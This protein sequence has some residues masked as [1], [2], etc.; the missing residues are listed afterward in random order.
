MSSVNKALALAL[1][2]L[3]I[4]AIGLGLLYSNISSLK[5]D[6]KVINSRIT[7]IQENVDRIQSASRGYVTQ[8]QLDEVKNTLDDI[9]KELMRLRE[10]LPNAATQED[11]QNI[12]A[13]ISE[14][15]EELS[16]LQNLEA[17]TSDLKDRI[18]SLAK[19]LN[20]LE[21][22]IQE[23]E[24]RIKFPV[25][26]VDATGSEV[27]VPSKP[28]RIVSLAPSTTEIIYFVGALDR[29]VGVDDYSDYP[30]VVKDMLENGTLTSIGGF[31]NP[32][33]ET[34]L[35]LDP[36]LVI[37]VDSTPHRQVKDVL[38]DY[39]IP[40]ILL[41]QAS[42]DDVKRSIIIA[43]MA[44]GN[45][46]EAVKVLSKINSK[47]A[48]V[49]KAASGIEDPVTVALIVWIN[50]IFVAGNETFQNDI[51]EFAGGVNV[52]ANLSGWP[53]ISPEDLVEANP[54]VILLSGINVTTFI[55]YL[56]SQVGDAA[57]DISAVANGR[58]YTIS[59]DYADMLSRPSPRV[60]DIIP[61]IQYIL[62]PELYGAQVSD[63][64][65]VISPE[66][67]PQVP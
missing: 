32:N 67:L 66:T 11:I 5:E 64:P 44:T 20:E 17:A 29:L 4:I 56:V 23:L 6:I 51:I 50:P 18:D 39:G 35:S 34:I 43:G 9:S 15:Q 63:I 46:D 59:G 3:V 57:L 49:K 14:I 37:G 16:R 53:T 33:I 38:E 30:P 19:Q 25:T 42:I 61:I 12:L 60:A 2:T 26:V 21:G 36:D 27:F 28:E 7:E 47:L 13:T 48:A 40:V 54:D 55:D 65:R 58:V 45:I 1:S 8:Q 41:P 24:E 22:R 10:M 62:Y 31:W 52:F